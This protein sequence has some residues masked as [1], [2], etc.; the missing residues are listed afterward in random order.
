MH[1]KSHAAFYMLNFSAA[2]FRC[3]FSLRICGL[4]TTLLVFSRYKFTPLHDFC[5]AS[6]LDQPI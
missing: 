3:T 1:I 5:G 4:K 2:D 6:W